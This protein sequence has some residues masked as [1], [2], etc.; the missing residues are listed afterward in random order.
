MHY[1]ELYIFA[2]DLYL[3]SLNH[4]IWKRL[5]VT[6]CGRLPLSRYANTWLDHDDV[7]IGLYCA[8]LAPQWKTNLSSTFVQVMNTWPLRYCI[9]R[10]GS[11][12]RKIAPTLIITGPKTDHFFVCKQTGF[13]DQRLW[14]F[15]KTTLTRVESFCQKTWL[16]SSHHFSQRGSSRVRVTKNR[17]LSQV[18][19]IHWLESRYHCLL[20]QIGYGL[21]CSLWVWR[22]KA[23]RR[24]CFPPVSNPSTSWTAWPDS[25]GRWDNRMAAQHLPRDLVQFSSGLKKWLKRRKRIGL[26]TTVF[27]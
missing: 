20:V 11:Q 22:R 6:V 14:D 21:L 15:A 8:R 19:S 25:C 24:P 1:I 7:S 26:Q 23:N 2:L 4:F 12:N 3:N 16:E 18:E 5:K 17:D 13:V 10:L 9:T 27:S